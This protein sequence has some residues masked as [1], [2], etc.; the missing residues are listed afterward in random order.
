MEEGDQGSHESWS[1]LV[2]P[3]SPIDALQALI[4]RMMSVAPMSL[5]EAEIVRREYVVRLSE[6]PSAFLYLRAND[7]LAHLSLPDGEREEAMKAMDRD[8]GA[9]VKVV[10]DSFDHWLTT[11]LPAAPY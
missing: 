11:G 3:T 4:E 8:L 2:T 6:D 10:G 7:P 5:S 9:Q 1:V